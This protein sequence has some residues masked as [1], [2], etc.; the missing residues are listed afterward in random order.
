MQHRGAA[1]DRANGASA[2]SGFQNFSDG[3]V[4]PTVVFPPDGRMAA[5]VPLNRGG[6]E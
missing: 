1:D 4:A 2:G 3:H 5:G 6:P